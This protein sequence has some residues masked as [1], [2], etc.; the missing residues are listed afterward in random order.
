VSP[1]ASSWI[2]YYIDTVPLANRLPTVRYDIKANSWELFQHN[3][4][5]TSNAPIKRIRHA[6]SIM[7]KGLDQAFVISGEI[8]NDNTWANGMLIYDFKGQTWKHKD[9]KWD[10][11]SMGVVN[12]LAFDD[13][14][15]GYILGFAGQAREVSNLWHYSSSQH[16]CSILLCPRRAEWT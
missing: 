8:V 5:T 14:S 1:P 9:T 16:S 11:W 6:Q 7:I 3:P 2:H 13:P 4:N 12:H 10:N 15:S